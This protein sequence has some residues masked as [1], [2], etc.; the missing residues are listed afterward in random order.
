M[1]TMVNYSSLQITALENNDDEG[2]DE[3]DD[4]EGTNDNS[5]STIEVKPTDSS[6]D[7]KVVRP[8]NQSQYSMH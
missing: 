3:G 8:N 4:D 5:D 2:D 7:D 6:V 1:H